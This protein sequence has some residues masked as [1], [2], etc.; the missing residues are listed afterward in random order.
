MFSESGDPYWNTV[1]IVIVPVPELRMPAVV[2]L[3]NII[4]P[5]VEVVKPQKYK[6]TLSDP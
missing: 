2:I 1:L 4:S 6:S 5:F 3:P